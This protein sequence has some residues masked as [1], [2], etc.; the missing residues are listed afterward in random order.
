MATKAAA[1]DELTPG[2][3]ELGA[4]LI[5]LPR[6]RLD[7]GKPHHEVLLVSRFAG[8]PDRI[9]EIVAD[10]IEARCMPPARLFAPQPPPRPQPRLAQIER[11]VRAA[12]RMEAEVSGL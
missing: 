6:H 7:R 3:C 4:V 1:T 12:M 9:L 8:V 10:E 2:Q 5:L 11:M